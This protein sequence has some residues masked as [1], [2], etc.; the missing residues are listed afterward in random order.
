LRPLFPNPRDRLESSERQPAV[1]LSLARMLLETLLISARW[2]YALLSSGRYCVRLGRDVAIQPSPNKGMGA[3]ALRDLDQGEILGRYTGRIYQDPQDYFRR[4][5]RNGFVSDY[6]L[7]LGS[8]LLIDAEDP[9]VSNWPRYINHSVRKAN[10]AAFDLSDSIDILYFEVTKPV[11]KGEELLFNY[12]K[13]LP[14]PAQTP[15]TSAGRVWH[16]A[17]ACSRPRPW[18]RTIGRRASRGHW[19]R[20]GWWWTICRRGAGARAPSS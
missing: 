9:K 18:C 16:A 11:A 19:T 4:T 5:G 14:R 8:G 2:N 3:F 15:G 13:V 12:G 10:C 1:G 20:G 17:H 7:M 6:T